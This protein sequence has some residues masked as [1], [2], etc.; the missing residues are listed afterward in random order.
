MADDESI[1]STE[2]NAAV[3]ASQ[4]GVS[5]AGGDENSNPNNSPEKQ[6]KRQ[7]V[8]LPLPPHLAVFTFKFK[9]NIIYAQESDRNNKENKATAQVAKYITST[10]KIKNIEEEHKKWIDLNKTT[11]NTI[12]WDESE[13]S[14]V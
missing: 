2:L 8:L 4:G 14:I 10:G 1:N 3:A 13:P 5:N 12:Y 9:A 7:K 11:A 6:K